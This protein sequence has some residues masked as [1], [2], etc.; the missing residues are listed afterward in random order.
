[1]ETTH[2]TWGVRTVTRQ[3]DNSLTAIL[4]LKPRKRCSFHLHKQ[5]Y[6]QFY[7][8]SGKLGIKTDIGP[9]K[10]E[11]IIILEKGQSFTV[12][13]DVNHEFRTYGEPTII[14]EIAYVKY[15][16]SDIYRKSMGGDLKESD[17]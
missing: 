13:P 1:M 6:N 2:G 11:N 9:D 8:I 14:E 7:V 4:Y 12:P 10:Q 15:D 17:E 16:S 3:T 5:A